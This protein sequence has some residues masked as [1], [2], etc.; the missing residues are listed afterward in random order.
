MG[1]ANRGRQYLKARARLR[2]SEAAARAA[3][4]HGVEPDI[5]DD[6]CIEGLPLE[7][8]AR[9]VP[10]REV[11][12]SEGGIRERWRL[13]AEAELQGSFNKLGAVAETTPD[14]LARAGGDTQSCP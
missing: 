14:E 12:R 1:R 10:D 6:A 2:K 13:A 4:A 3:A 8:G 11:R 7:P 9:A 5:I